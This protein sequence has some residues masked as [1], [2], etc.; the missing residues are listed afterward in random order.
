MHRV[1]WICMVML[2]WGMLRCLHRGGLGIEL[3][4]MRCYNLSLPFMLQLAQNFFSDTIFIEFGPDGRHNIV[5]D[6]PI[7]CRLNDTKHPG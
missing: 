6:S 4:N 7:D 1:R 5:Y 2:R 3:G